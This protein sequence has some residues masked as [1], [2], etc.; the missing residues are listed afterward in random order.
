MLGVFWRG[1]GVRVQGSGF[2][3]KVSIIDMGALL[4]FLYRVSKHMSQ[5]QLRLSPQKH[6]ADS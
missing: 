1:L 6:V 4:R 5:Q 2:W 3:I